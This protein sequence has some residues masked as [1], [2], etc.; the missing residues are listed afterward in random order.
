MGGENMSANHGTFYDLT[1]NLIDLGLNL[2]GYVWPFLVL[3]VIVMVYRAV[4]D[5]GVGRREID[6]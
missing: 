6:E 3:A 5:M 4:A 2:A 1:Q